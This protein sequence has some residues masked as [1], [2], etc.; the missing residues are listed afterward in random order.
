MGGLPDYVNSGPP[1]TLNEDYDPANDTWTT[2]APMPTKRHALTATLGPDGRIYALG[3]TNNA[4]TDMNV[5]EIYDPIANTWTTGA[6][7][8]YGQECAASTFSAGASG[9]V[10]VMGGWDKPEKVAVSTVAAYNPRTRTWRLLPSVPT[11]RAG[12][13]AVR[14][15][16]LDGGDGCVHLYFIGGA[17]QETSVEEYAFR[18]PPLAPTTPRSAHP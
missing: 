1:T 13:G 9:E 12:G 8:P 7:M 3:G 17:P 5:M 11:G 10:F 14:L 4:V 15:D 6:A 2:R 18:P 16:R